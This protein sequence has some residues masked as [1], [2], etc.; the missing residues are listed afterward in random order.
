MANLGQEAWPQLIPWAR[1]F[2]GGSLGHRTPT[3]LRWQV[4][5]DRTPVLG[6]AEWGV[7]GAGSLVGVGQRR[8]QSW[9]QIPVPPLISGIRLLVAH[10]P[11]RC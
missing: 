5:C 7:Q 1:P 9:V 3:A 6:Q 8:R 4:V 11:K 2:R 10:S